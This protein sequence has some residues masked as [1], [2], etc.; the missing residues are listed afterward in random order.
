LSKEPPNSAPPP[1]ASPLWGGY[2]Q[3]A[4]AAA[5]SRHGEQ[6]QPLSRRLLRAAAGLTVLL[7][8]VIVNSL[9]NQ[10]DESP[11]NPNPVAE[12]AEHA[13]QMPGARFSLYVV[14]SSAALPQPLTASGSGAYNAETKRSRVSLDLNSSPIGPVHV[15]TISDSDFEYTSGDTVAD[16]L[17]PGKEWV[18][19]AK[20]SED[21]EPSRDMGDSLQMLSSSGGVR[22]LGHESVNGKMTRRYRGEI[23]LG[24]FVD[25]LRAAGKDDVADAYERIEGLAPTGIS[26]EAWVDRKNM[27]RRLRMV[28]P[29]PAK[30][31]G[32]EVTVDMRMDFFDYGARPAIQLPAPE[33]V[34]EGPL[35][36]GEAPASASFS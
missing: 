26:A 31:G 22:L 3:G 27:L 21:D 10:G 30:E 1:G 14:Y 36:S 19:V 25:Y 11:F 35:D 28:M 17:P 24:D 6:L 9:V 23:Q 34:V 32:P 4:A 5:P 2:E 16:E 12:A 33:R 8:L 13:E 29:M 20:G 7:F 15:V 18:K